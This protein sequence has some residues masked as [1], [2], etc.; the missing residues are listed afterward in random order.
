MSSISTGSN[1]ITIGDNTLYKGI[2]SN[3]LHFVIKYK[4]YSKHYKDLYKCNYHKDNANITSPDSQSCDDHLSVAN[5]RNNK[6][7]EILK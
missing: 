3:C 5:N 2:C 4:E 7:D 1:N 6:I